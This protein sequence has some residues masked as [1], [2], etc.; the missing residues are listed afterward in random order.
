ENALIPLM[1]DMRFAGVSVDVSK[2]ERLRDELEGKENILQDKL[3]KAAG[4]PVNVNAADDIASAFDAAGL[5]YERTAKGNPS[6][7]KQSLETIDHPLARGILDIRR[8]NKLRSTFVESYVLDS[9]VDG[10]LYGQF[11][12]LRGEGGGTRSG[13]FSSSTPNL[14]NIPSRDDE[15]A[16]LIRGLFI[17]DDGHKQWV[18]NDY[19][20][21]EY[22]FLAHFAVGEGSSSVRQAYQ[23]NPDIDYHS[24]VQD[25]V[26]KATGV[27]LDR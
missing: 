18:R 6:F 7:T 4:Q 16:P 15:L 8:I 12:Q 23:D 22:R 3:D 2:A 19:S 11:H 17:P 21:I 20:Q 26:R 25:M 10:R 5:R 24:M 9:H 1:V 14:Q 13:R 27:H